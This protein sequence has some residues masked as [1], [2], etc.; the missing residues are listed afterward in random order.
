MFMSGKYE[1]A[2]A[3]ACLCG[4]CH[5]MAFVR[6]LAVQ[7]AAE[8][9]VYSNLYMPSL[10]L[11]KLFHVTLSYCVLCCHSHFNIRM[12]AQVTVSLAQDLIESDNEGF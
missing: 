1:R 11:Y 10:R 9:C 6:S 8:M 3:Q 5:D 4:F 2:S 12:S 7:H